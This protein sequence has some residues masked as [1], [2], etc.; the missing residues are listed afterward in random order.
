MPRSRRGLARSRLTIV[1]SGLG[2]AV[3]VGVFRG[4][5]GRDL[6]ELVVLAFGAALLL[7]VAGRFALGLGSGRTVSV[8]V[9]AICVALVSVGATALGTMAAAR[10]MFVSA[11]DLDALFVVL[12]AAATV[13]VLGAVDVSRRW[14]DARSRE[15]SLDRARRELVAWVSHDLR[16]PLAGVRAMVEALDDGVV[17]DPDGIKRYHRAIHT[18]TERL[19]RLVDDL[20]ELSRIQADAL[21]LSLERVSLGDVVSDA[22]SSAQPLAE[23]KGVQLDGRVQAPLLSVALATPEMGRLLRN[24][25]DNAIRHTPPGGTVGVEV[26]REGGHAV[27]AVTDECGGI[28]EDD[29]DRVF[30]LA[31]RGDAART[32]DD[33][34][35]GLGLA[36]AK[37]LA[38]AHAGDLHVRNENGG[39]RFMVRLP[40]APR[41]HRSR[42]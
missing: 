3:L 25:L 29:L 9:Q 24:L 10:A 1:V 4:L 31:Y 42:H 26:D 40:L 30:E 20:F 21:S 2:L 6:A 19:A 35:G 33:R 12:V 38:E 11:H 14:D 8:R 5:P 13:G 28:A 34:G 39:C 17:D 36:I 32:P 18:E 7:G 22:V 37:G 23:A 27:V 15:Q 16:T 41:H